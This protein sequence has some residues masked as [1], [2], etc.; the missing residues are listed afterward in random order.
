MP[1]FQDIHQLVVVHMSSFSVSDIII[2]VS[3]NRAVRSLGLCPTNTTASTLRFHTWFLSFFIY[4][5]S[6]THYRV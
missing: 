6:F 5:S 1:L 2:S 3:Y 4:L